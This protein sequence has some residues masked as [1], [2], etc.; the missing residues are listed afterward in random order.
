MSQACCIRR[1]DN[2]IAVRAALASFESVNTANSLFNSGGVWMATDD[3]R[4][5]GTTA[6]MKTPAGYS[7]L[8]AST[9]DST[10]GNSSNW[11]ASESGITGICTSGM[12]AEVFVDLGRLVDSASTERHRCPALGRH[13]RK[14]SPA[15][16]R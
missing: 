15:H 16:F 3:Q 13:A 8:L 6:N 7:W 10:S 9:S 12:R 11:V 1:F 4:G 2:V 14:D 5:A